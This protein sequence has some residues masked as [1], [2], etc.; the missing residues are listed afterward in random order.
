MSEGRAEQLLFDLAQR[1][2]LGAE[3]FIVSASNQ[4]AVDL[5]DSYP[6]W[7]DRVV[8]LVGP[9]GSL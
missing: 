1:P 3:D 6:Q 7:R 9:E 2:A 8:A 5:V 4:A